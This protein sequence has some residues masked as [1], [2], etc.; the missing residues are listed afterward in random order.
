MSDSPAYPS[1]IL[2][3]LAGGAAGDALGYTVEFST[4]AQIQERY[5]EGGLTHP[6]QLEAIRSGQTIPVSDDTQL[7]LFVLDGLLDWI[8]WS[9]EGS[10]ADPAACVW[11][12]CLRWYRTQTGHLPEGAPEPPSRW[13]EDHRELQVQRAPGQ[14]CLSGLGSKDMGLPRKPQNPQARGCG[15][16]MRS[17]PYGMVPGLEESTV[18]SLAHQG[19]VLTHGHPAAWTSAAAFALMISRLMA[20]HGFSAALTAALDWLET[21]PDDGGTSAALRMAGRLAGQV[22][23]QPSGQQ[24]SFPVPAELGAGWVADEALAIAVYCVLVTEPE[25]AP[26]P[27]VHFRTALHLAVN[28]DGDSDSTAALAGQLLGARYGMEIFV[29]R[30]V[31]TWIGE[32]DVVSEAAERWITA[33]T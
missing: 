8:E 4:L 11:L 19:A 6:V 31:P 1:R 7:T 22:A 21:L 10:M 27:S 26:E 15:T 2:G 23:G 33:T 29:E 20:G 18:V 9:N 24:Q 32:R 25:T 16:V 30:S 12:S 13:L 17:A 28:H 5:G 14:A 3:L